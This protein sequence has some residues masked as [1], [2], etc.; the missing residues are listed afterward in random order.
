MAHG[1]WLLCLVL[2]AALFTE[3]PAHGKRIHIHPSVKPGTQLVS[4]ADKERTNYRL[5]FSRKANILREFIA[6]NQLTGIVTLH[7]QI[8]CGIFHN[9]V[10]VVTV[11]SI[12]VNPPKLYFWEP[13]LVTLHNRRGCLDVQKA[14]M[15]SNNAGHMQISAFKT[16]VVSRFNKSSGNFLR[17]RLK[18]SLG[19]K[20]YF[21]DHLYQLDRRTNFGTS[22]KDKRDASQVYLLSGIN[23]YQNRQGKTDYL[24]RIKRNARNTAPKFK[25][26]FESVS[27]LENVNVSTLVY[28]ASVS[29]SYLVGK[30]VYTMKPTGNIRSGDFFVINAGTGEIRTKASLDRESMS[31][32]QFRVT[33]TVKRSQT[34]QASMDLTIKILDVNDHAPVFDKKVYREN[35]SELEDSGSTVLVVR[36][37]DLD[38]GLN[39]DVRYS[40]VYHSGKNRVFVI[41]VTSG[42]IKVDDDLD[43]E[44]VPSY[45]LKIKAEDLGTPRQSSTV[46]VFINL[47]DEND[48]IPKFNETLYTFSV[49]ENSARG[50]FVGT[51]NATDCDIGLNKKIKYSITSGNED[52][53]FQIVMSS[54]VIRVHG[55]LDYETNSLY[56]LQVMAEDSGDSPEYSEVWVNIDV[57]DV[58]DCPPEFTKSNYHFSVS[59]SVGLNHLVETVHATDCDSGKN[60]EVEY[61]LK[62]KKLPFK[63]GLTSGEIKTTAKLDRETVPS[64]QFEVIAQDK[65]EKPLK[66]PVN[67][68]ITISDIND[69]P[70]KFEKDRYNASIDEKYRSRRPFLTVVAK[71]KDTIGQ[72]KYSLLEEP[73]NCFAINS[74]GGITK[75]RTCQLNYRIKRVY[76]F[77]VEASDGKQSSSAQVIVR[78]QDSNDNAPVFTKSRYTGEIYENETSGTNIAKVTAT[79]DDFGKNAEITYSILGGSTIFKINPGNGVITNLVMLDREHTSKYKL[80]VVATDNGK[81]SKS[82][83]TRVDITVKDINDNPP[84]F[85]QSLYMVEVFEN[86][87]VGKLVKQIQATDADEGVNKQISYSLEAKGNINN[88][89]KINNDLGDITVNQKLDREIIPEYTL[90]VVATDH[91]EPAQRSSTKVKVT[92]KD[93]LDSPPKFIK[94][95]YVVNIP[96]NYPVK[97]ELVRVKAVTQ[98]ILKHANIQ[99]DITGGNYDNMFTILGTTGSIELV[100]SLDFESKTGY[101]LTVQAMYA[102]FLAS[103]EVE[104][105][106]IDVNDM[107]PILKQ[108]FEILINILEGQFPSNI[109]FRIP[110][111]DPDKSSVLSYEITLKNDRAKNAVIVDKNT[112]ILS[113]KESALANTN[114]IPFKVRI[115]DGVHT[116]SRDGSINLNIIT[117]RLL[118]ASVTV[119]F[120]NAT[121]SKFFEVLHKF[122]SILGS[123]FDVDERN[124]IVFCV[125]NSTRIHND[126]L[127]EIGVVT[128]V[129]NYLTLWL[130]VRSEKGF[131]DGKL[132]LEKLHFY[133][134]ELEVETQMTL[135]PS[136]KEIKK[137]KDSSHY[138]LVQE[139]FT[140]KDSYFIS[141]TNKSFADSP[142]QLLIT[143]S[144]VFY[145]VKVKEVFKPFCPA[146]F[147]GTSCNFRLDTCYSSPCLNRAKCINY[148][149][150]Y[151]CACAENFVGKNCEIDMRKSRCSSLPD[152]ICQN[153]GKCKDDPKQGFQCLCENGNHLEQLCRVTTRSFENGSFA[154][155]SGL[156]QRWFIDVSLEFATVSSNGVLVYVGRY[157]YENDTMALELRNGKL[158]YVFSAGDDI[159]TVSVGPAE[160]ES[161]VNGKWHKVSIS[162]QQRTGALVLGK[163][164][165]SSVAVKFGNQVGRFSCAAADKLNGKLRSMDLTSPLVLGGLSVTPT[166]FPIQ[167][168][169]FNG[170]IRNVRLN[171]AP[172]DLGDPIFNQ[173]SKIGCNRKKDFCTDESCTQN[174]KCASSWEKATCVCQEKYA[175]K[176]CEIETSPLDFTSKSYLVNKLESTVVKQMWRMA[177][178]FR[179]VHKAGT[180][181]ELVFLNNTSSLKLQ[182]GGI[183]YSHNTN[184]SLFN[185][186]SNNII[187]D[188]GNWHHVDITSSM[189]SVYMIIDHVH[190][191]KAS[192]SRVTSDSLLQVV[193]GDTAKSG[194]G[195]IGC[196]KGVMIGDSHLNFSSATTY[197]VTTG[198]S[199]KAQCQSHSCPKESICQE[200]WGKTSCVCRKGYVGND[201]RDICTLRPCQNG[202]TCQRTNDD[203]GFRCICRDK[204]L[205]Q[206]CETRSQLP[207]RDEFF[208]ASDS[209]T[210]G[211][212]NCDL[213]LE[214]N[215]VCNK[216]TGECYCKDSYYRPILSSGKLD[217]VCE[218]C[219]CDDLGSAN[220]M[221]EPIGGQCPCLPGVIGRECDM[222][223]AKQG[224][225]TQSGKGCK[226]I[227]T[228]CPRAKAERIVWPRESFGV[229]SVQKCPFG[230]EGTAK[231]LCAFGTG[232]EEPD[233]L[234]CTS[235]GFLA[236][237]KLLKHYG[238]LS[239]Q[240]AIIV[241][242][243]L[244]NMFSVKEFYQ[245]DVALGCKIIM[246]LLDFESNQVEDKLASSQDKKFLDII[247]KAI[248]IFVD[249]KYTKGWSLID[250]TPPATVSLMRQL[251][252]FGISLA[253]N[254]VYI[255][256]NNREKRSTSSLP[257]YN[258]VE[259]HLLMQ[260]E[261]VDPKSFSGLQFPLKEHESSLLS[262]EQWRNTSNRV[263]IPESLFRNHGAP[264]NESAIA[265]IALKYLGDLLPYSFDTKASFSDLSLDVN[266][267]VIIV[268]IK[269]ME[270]IYLQEPITI[271]FEIHEVN[272]SKYDCVFWNYSVAGEHGGG[273]SRNGCTKAPSNFTHT[274][275]KCH[276]LTSFAVVS[277]LTIQIP[278]I[279]PYKIRIVTYIG[280]AISLVI[281]LGAIIT[282]TCLSGLNSNTN[283]I[284]RNMVL[285]IVIA[286]IVYV[287]GINRTSNQLICRF[288][289]II[290]HYFFDAV[291]AWM[292]VE[293]V[294]MYRRL[295][296]KRDIDSGQMTFYYFLGWGCPAIVVGLS[297]GMAVE[298][299][300]NQKFCW[301][302]TDGTLIWTF[303]IPIASVIFANVI[304][305][306]MALRLSVEKARRK[307]KHYTYNP[308]NVNV[309]SVH[310]NALKIK[311]ALKVG[312]IFLP[313]LG[314]TLTFG[315]LAV[316][317]DLL[318]FHYLYAILC[319]CQSLFVLLFYVAFD[320]KVREEYKNAYIRWRTGDKTY[321]RPRRRRLYEMSYHPGSNLA[322][323]EGYGLKGMNPETTS[324]DRSTSTLHSMSKTDPFS[325]FPEDD[326]ES[327]YKEIKKRKPRKEDPIDMESAAK[328]WNAPEKSEVSTTQ[329]ESS[330]SSDGGRRRETMVISS[331]SGSSGDESGSWE[332]KSENGVNKQKAT[333]PL[334]ASDGP[335]HSTPMELAQE[336]E[337]LLKK[338]PMTETPVATV[339]PLPRPKI[340]S[341]LKNSSTRGNDA[342]QPDQSSPQL[343]TKPLPEMKKAG[344]E[345]SS[346]SSLSSMSDDDNDLLA[347]AKL[348][349]QSTEGGMSTTS[350]SAKKR[351]SRK[352]RDMQ[353]GKKSRNHRVHFNRKKSK[354]PD[355]S[356]KEKVRTVEGEEGKPLTEQQV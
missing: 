346:G 97:K 311:Y 277:D 204:Y 315:V 271:E 265:F 270:S 243:K 157:G 199:S 189:M 93:I 21:S 213:R 2:W 334:Y 118:Q 14:K 47:I 258:K 212:C 345:A 195:F 247:L 289:A 26:P 30:L 242:R 230:A 73:D 77:K 222:C 108:N 312:A 291:F 42:I 32:H 126:F 217:D 159:K 208:S 181:M 343:A 231:R 275:C 184:S 25:N 306:L 280:V 172:L 121:T 64:Y 186:K 50:T 168:K 309:T 335:M 19:P 125:V 196:I 226:I 176:K 248:S 252:S 328:M 308:K 254:M 37:Y 273:W 100:K 227:N 6:I 197:L 9:K 150:G 330:D 54:G 260:L 57:T 136:D 198:C 319:C 303:T 193:L 75:R 153:Q 244:W 147:F 112:G 180:I 209:G 253:S 261:P 183:H 46:D 3:R 53:A 149:G 246:A 298:G 323:E 250:E 68:Y 101:L 171:H 333:A 107:K 292:F 266:S 29:N 229:V 158:Y 283:N 167:G 142:G 5:S 135:L 92:L 15:N 67:V 297:T 322:G 232:W 201:C 16:D 340:L 156:S 89:F 207:C 223:Q 255:K 144:A 307:R 94:P 336:K 179:T 117:E 83:R 62:N 267:D 161:I 35:I 200:G 33:A 10:F 55:S 72:I 302:T 22:H 7:R 234:N 202:A 106:V 318:I 133:A 1:L 80:K 41:G 132:V 284:H 45:H 263:N 105:N 235:A 82:G 175:G 300:G 81:R 160:G 11:Q 233:L 354:N 327:D 137:G 12:S 321:G 165:K 221:C 339:E 4:L 34:L 74:F 185:L 188:D 18:D 140:S 353:H 151:Y 111:Y 344:S 218:Q 324:T 274:V 286:E 329:P 316:N 281:L 130:A 145:G 116:I 43:R 120:K 131:V 272:R 56:M 182:D 39:K 59:E 154:A 264:K 141:M 310:K 205:G 249:P 356:G 115:S 164:C 349:S 178:M 279:S 313:V 224:E 304:V 257:S 337:R 214:Y 294:H 96:E 206:F 103:A 91:G 305:F 169:S 241:S 104:I 332:K 225:I 48:C 44:K 155:F 162:Y 282:F 295:T 152:N 216:T 148:E 338:K 174:G 143:P 8:T 301:M 288:I 342:P 129:N 317:Q 102:T 90:T 70:P 203:V 296:E 347:Q 219:R 52:Q 98:D 351:R 114:R 350:S 348:L 60:A 95:R 38:S 352:T 123:I 99:Y 49:K 86:V 124:V 58:N 285:A 173:N 326:S 210:C 278:V 23:G 61:F 113:I 276:H 138:L 238:N 40:I 24:T 119:Y 192:I 134:K 268:G 251:E 190:K 139:P 269:G 163:N 87:P 69:S 355:D 76:Y 220:Q 84:K 239:T 110:A 341:I 78:I 85:D 166:S 299:Y 20:N 211:P 194:N 262:S 228:S 237:I 71:D 146:G 290:L 293:V 245:K 331:D 127:D 259:K 256:R 287:L 17:S 187:L 325:T 320:P 79:D 13:I 27:I 51:T 215:P 314:I 240:T 63:I 109:N 66:K 177:V 128:I 28:T 36:A 65:G 31:E 236:I 88:A 122:K 170:C 191:V